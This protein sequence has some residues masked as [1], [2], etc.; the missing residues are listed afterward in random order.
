MM[1]M[2][3]TRRIYQRRPLPICISSVGTWYIL[4]LQPLS[5]TVFQS[6]I[7]M[8]VKRTIVITA[9]YQPLALSGFLMIFSLS[10]IWTQLIF[11]HLHLSKPCWGLTQIVTNLSS[12][13]RKQLLFGKQLVR[14]KLPLMKQTIQAGD[15]AA[16]G[17]SVSVFEF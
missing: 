6:M 11:S 9:A 13:C 7:R 15:L 14:A 1:T 17:I 2:T 5:S 10:K 16:N 4:R 12:F 8:W 3:K